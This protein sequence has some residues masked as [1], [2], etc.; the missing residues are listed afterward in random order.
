M[1]ALGVIP[2][3]GNAKRWGGYFKELLPLDGSYTF[4]DRA[5]RSMYEGGANKVVVISKPDKLATHAKH[6]SA[7]HGTAFY[8]VQRE[9]EL[10][11]AI[12]EGLK[13]SQDLNFFAMP[14]TYYPLDV[15]MRSFSHA[16]LHLGL[17]KT[18]M[19]ERFGVLHKGKIIDK[20]FPFKKLCDET[21]IEFFAWGVLAW[22]NNVS[23]FWN[24]IH[25][26]TYTDALNL[27]M[28]TFTWDTFELDY[29][30]D[31]AS[32]DDYESFIQSSR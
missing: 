24:N 7:R 32:W 30:Y 15:F 31:M 11:G 29:Y 16:D 27:A 6:I 9:P 21:S 23:E 12:K 25:G 13:F 14:D 1:N 28:K 18:K 17:F 3:A 8:A 22:S 4:L 10:F 26:A 19:P 20:Y 2:A 5:I